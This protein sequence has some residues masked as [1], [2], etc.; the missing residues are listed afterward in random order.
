M[1]TFDDTVQLAAPPFHHPAQTRL[2]L[3]QRI[4]LHWVVRCLIT[5]FAFGLIT[6]ASVTGLQAL[7]V[8]I[9]PIISVGMLAMSSLLAVFAVT[10]LLERRNLAEIGLGWRRFVM[11]WLKGA[12]V[13]AVYICVALGILGELFK[14]RPVVGIHAV[15]LVLGFGSLHCLTQ[16]EPV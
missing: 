10:W 7:A 3:V 9:G 6:W 15:D 14:D 2:P 13:G 16:Q 8:E 4:L 1:N 12:G 11:D 5:W